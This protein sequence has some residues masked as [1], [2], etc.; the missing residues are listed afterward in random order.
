M[1]KNLKFKIRPSR[2]AVVK[3]LCVDIMGSHY[4][5]SKTYY[6]YKLKYATP[7]GPDRGE[8]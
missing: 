1:N 7:W 4:V 2:Y 8:P 6:G 3:T 5:C